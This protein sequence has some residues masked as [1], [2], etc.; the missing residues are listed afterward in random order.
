VAQ[1][2]TGL[3]TSKR[4]SSGGRTLPG[5]GIVSKATSLS[6]LREAVPTLSS[7]VGQET[8]GCVIVGNNNKDLIFCKRRMMILLINHSIPMEKNLS[9]RAHRYYQSDEPGGLTDSDREQRPAPP[10]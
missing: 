1:S 6:L 9:R 2:Y 5:E 8:P 7:P 4:G 10:D 3:R